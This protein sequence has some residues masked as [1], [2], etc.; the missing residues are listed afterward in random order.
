MQ[1]EK[2]NYQDE[3]NDV[4]NNMRVYI[5]MRFA[6]LTLFIAITAVLINAVFGD[7]STPLSNGASTGLKL[8]G[9]ITGI[10]FLIMEIRA[11]DIYHHFKRRAIVLEEKL[12][13][14]QYTTRREA[15]ILSATNATMA[16]IAFI[17]AL[18]IVAIVFPQWLQ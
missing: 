9:L 18:W 4:S 3:Y 2:P 1:N 12:K 8:G 10:V 16:F 15:K 6:Q 7:R 5:N 13:F 11:A 17:I 14:Q